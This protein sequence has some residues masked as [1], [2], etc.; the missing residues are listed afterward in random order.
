M[1][2]QFLTEI[3][4]GIKIEFVIS[5]EKHNGL[6]RSNPHSSVSGSQVSL[7]SGCSGSSSGGLEK[8]AVARLAKAGA[9]LTASW[10]SSWDRDMLCSALSTNSASATTSAT[11]T[12]Q[13]SKAEAQSNEGGECMKTSVTIEDFRNNESEAFHHKKGAKAVTQNTT[14]EGQKRDLLW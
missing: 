9:L 12:G 5:A 8:S 3:K 10:A 11:T 4:P 14:D 1:K 13:P 7:D 6:D 2:G